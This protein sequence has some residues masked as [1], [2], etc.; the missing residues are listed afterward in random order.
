M[1]LQGEEVDV[2]TL[3]DGSSKSGIAATW[4]EVASN[5]YFGFG[6]SCSYRG[7][8]CCAVYPDLRM[9][10]TVGDQPLVETR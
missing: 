4:E 6:F 5:L 3:S 8:Q 9:T 1:P 10:I 7:T 2:L